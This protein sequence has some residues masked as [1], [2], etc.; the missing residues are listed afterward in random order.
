MKRENMRNAPHHRYL[1]ALVI[2]FVGSM[3]LIGCGSAQDS[4]NAAASAPETAAPGSLDADGEGVPDV[5]RK[6]LSE[7]MDTLEKAGYTIQVKGEKIKDWKVPD[8][9]KDWEVIAQNPAAGKDPEKGDL[10]QLAVRE[11]E[12]DDGGQ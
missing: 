7:A 8:N 11:N 4:E 3:A 12:A 6:P 5:N 10:V 9:P 1:T 2:P